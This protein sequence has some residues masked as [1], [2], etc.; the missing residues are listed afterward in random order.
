MS[1]ACHNHKRFSGVCQ[2]CLDNKGEGVVLSAELQA[3]LSRL[4]AQRITYEAA[5]KQIYEKYCDS[6]CFSDAEWAL[7][8]YGVPLPTMPWDKVTL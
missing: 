5:L 4:R 7:E 6:Y 3:T 1:L 2:A 8:T